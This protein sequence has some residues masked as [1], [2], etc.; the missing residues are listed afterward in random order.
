MLAFTDWLVLAGVCAL[1]AMTPGAS[2][3]VISRHSLV[4]GPVAGAMAALAHAAGIGLWALASVTGMAL[5]L[6]R[7]PG[8]E[9]AF[10]LAGSGLLLWLA[11]QSWQSASAPP[12]PAS[13]NASARRLHGAV[14]D[15]FSIAF[16]NPKVGL[17]FLALFSQ[18]LEAGMG[19]AARAQMVLT[20][21]FIDGGWYLLVVTMLGRGRLPARLRAQHQWLE[22]GT[23]LLLSAIALTML[24]RTFS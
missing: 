14:R 7:H 3:A 2:L 21:T 9:M 19:V 13:D 12:P 23:A 6:Q 11:H 17:F 16:L 10:T 20:A 22:R 5:L 24:V 18:F 15:G 8:L 4:G 1:G